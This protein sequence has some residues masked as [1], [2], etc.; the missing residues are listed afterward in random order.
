MPTTGPKTNGA[1]GP[2]RVEALERRV[3]R[4]LGRLGSRPMVHVTCYEQAGRLFCMWWC[5]THVGPC[6][7]SVRG[8][9]SDDDDERLAARVRDALWDVGTAYCETFGGG[10]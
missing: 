2:R 8:S 10:R 6:T 5:E 1:D 7:V 3:R 9:D 4:M